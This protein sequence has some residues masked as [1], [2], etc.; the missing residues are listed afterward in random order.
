MKSRRL[1]W[2]TATILL[3]VMAIPV[4]LSAQEI[5][6][7]H[8][9]Y[10]LI[11]VGTLGGPTSFPPN[12]YALDIN[13]HG[14]AIAEAETSIPD[15]NAP[16][17]FQPDCLVNHAITWQNGLQTDLGT[18]PGG[19]GSYPSWSNDQGTV[20]GWSENGVIDPLT[21]GSLRFIGRTAR[22]LI[23]ARWVGMRAT[24]RPSITGVRWSEKH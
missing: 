16:N 18:L 17:C 14:L 6:A 12:P 21:G 19:H 13:S 1:M 24:H 20:V 15:P 3:G 10:K 9:H 11:D 22:F 7:K 8:R 4:Q 23:L 5:K 2:F